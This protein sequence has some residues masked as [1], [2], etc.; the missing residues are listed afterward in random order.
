MIPMKHLVMVYMEQNK[1]DRPF[2]IVCALG[3]PLSITHFIIMIIITVDAGLR[4]CAEGRRAVLLAAY[5][6][7]I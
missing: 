4:H 3:E 5:M 7:S 2:F 1:T 6:Y